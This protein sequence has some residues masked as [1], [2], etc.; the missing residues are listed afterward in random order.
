MRIGYVGLGNMGGPLAG[1][2]LLRHPLHVYDLSAEAV[3]GFKERGAIA[4]ENPADLAGRCDVVFTCLPKSDHVHEVIF[5]ADGLVQAMQPGGLIV[6]MTTGDPAK[7][8][9]MAEELESRQINLID[10][11]VSGG[12]RG[13]N[14]GTIAIMV[15]APQEVYARV[16]PLLEA[17]SSNIFHAGGVGAGHA[18]KAGNNLLNLACRL[19]TFEVISLLVKNG[20]APEDA[21]A[22][23]QKSSGRSYATEITL[24]DNILSGKM[25]QG[26]WMDLMRKDVA[27]ALDLARDSD[28]PMPLG[29]LAREQLLA[30]IEEHGGGADMSALA[31]T[32]ERI[33]GA[34][35]RPDES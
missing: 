30:A 10:A 34:R 6:D 27:I 20:V 26:F 2:L 17:I 1:R 7:T 14:E 29:T 4:A 9:A 28:V 8:R 11:P 3:A 15:G 18:V 33:T 19:M 16:L 31:L 22:I 23:I 25:H 35:I 32:Y 5:A 13:A 21:V 12:P 24:P